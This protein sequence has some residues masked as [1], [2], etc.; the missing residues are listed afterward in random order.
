MRRVNDPVKYETHELAVASALVEAIRAELEAA[1]LTGRTLR[2]RT[3]SIA[4][5]VAG[6]YDGSAH[7]SVGDDHAVPIVG[8]AVGRMRDRLLLPE[9]G[10]SSVHGFVP[11]AV[12]SEFRRER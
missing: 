12:R 9:E 5:S 8:F 1:G 10:G 4:F 3:E 7:V 2:R 11:G 6:I